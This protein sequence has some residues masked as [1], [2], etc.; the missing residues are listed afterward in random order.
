MIKYLKIKDNLYL[1]QQVVKPEQQ[2]EQVI[3]LST[4]HIFVIDCSGSMSG[5]LSTI[6]KDLFNKISTILKPS[7]SVTIIWFSGRNQYGVILEDYTVHSNIALEK[8]REII[9]KYLTPQGLTAFKQPLEEV[10]SVIERV[11][12]NNPNMLHS[13]FFLTDGYDNQFSTKEILKATSELSDYLNSATIVEYGWYCNRELLSQMAQE[14][15]GVHT[16]SQNFQDYEPYL[17]KQFTADNRGKRTYIELSDTPSY[18]MVFNVVDGDVVMYKTNENN[19]ILINVN[20]DT[21]IFYF[22][23]SSV[24]DAGN[25]NVHNLDYVKEYFDNRVESEMIQGLYASLFAFSRKSDYVMV[26]EILKALGDAHFITEKANTFGTQKIN[27]LEAKF[28]D[29]A[30]DSSKRYIDGY[31]PN[32]EPAEDAYCVLDMMQDLMTQEGNYWYPQHEA[33]NYKR[34]GSK[35]IAK[36]T[37]LSEEDRQKIDDLLDSK[38]LDEAQQLLEEIKKN[39]P[40]QLKFHHFGALQAF[41]FY[42]L[43]WNETR[44]N[45]SVQVNYKGHVE[46]PDNEFG[47]P[48][49]FPTNQFRN[50]TLIKDGIVYNYTLPISLGRETFNKL[51]SNG[52]LEGE[53]YEENKIYILEFS[54]LPVI[55]RKMIGTLSATEL[56]TNEWELLKLKS[57]NAV[58]NYY[59]KL[60]FQNTSKGFVEQFG[61]EATEWLAT[62]GLKD[63]GFNPPKSVEKQGEQIDVNVLEVKIDKMST[64][65]GKK[66]I[67]SAEKKINSKDS[68]TPKEALVE[69]AIKEVNQFTGLIKEVTNQDKMLEDWLYQKSKFFRTE[70]NRL[71]S[72]ISKAKFLTIVGKSWFKEFSDRS[73]NEMTLNLDSQ[74]VKFKVE[75]KIETITI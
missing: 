64:T 18:D 19:E 75:D 8:V 44:A 35:T 11:R 56:F 20:G 7:D 73:Q 27:E 65:P 46:L 66:E 57:S 42:D 3:E 59:K 34:I 69:N 24:V 1:A 2:K 72:E 10:K 4:Q 29:A 60:K 50:Y 47:L 53:Y 39:Q 9:N 41:P 63:Y 36:M 52:L 21:N 33:F 16:F 31:N 38:K 48:T 71:M 15:G 25:N 68:L 17:T 37:D 40:T 23:D 45:L 43:V 49:Q 30:N 28:L 74:D 13:M 51:Q 67:E 6:R 14:I 58:Y 54:K 22:T 26:S 62:F 32:L 61:K 70:K 5:E 55:N 12:G